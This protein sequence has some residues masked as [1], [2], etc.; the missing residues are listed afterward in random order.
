MGSSE[1][2]AAGAGDRPGERLMAASVKTSSETSPWRHIDPLLVVLPF[3]IT[4]LGLLMIYSS[5]KSRLAA[6]G[7]EPAVLRRPPGPRDRIGIVAMVIVI[8]IDYG[9]SATSGARVHRGDPV[10]HRC[11]RHRPQPQGAQAGSRWA[12]CSSKPSELTKAR[13]GG[14]GRGLLPRASR[15]PRRG[16]LAVALALAGFAMALV[17]LQHDPA[18]RS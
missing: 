13:G 12:Q 8:A 2:R 10:A 5:S 14:R 7:F 1:E 16:R 6:P 17:F 9:A 3:A 15:R 18:P 11:A 4:A